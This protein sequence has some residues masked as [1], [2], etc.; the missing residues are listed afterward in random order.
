M[1]SGA[2]RNKK[3]RRVEEPQKTSEKNIYLKFVYSESALQ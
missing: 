1:A 2:R 3:K